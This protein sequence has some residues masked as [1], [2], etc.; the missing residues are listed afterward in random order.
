MLPAAILWDND[1][2]LVDTEI[3]YFE[4]TRGVLAEVEFDL[5]RDV[6]VDF[7][8]RQGRSVFE[9]LADRL[10]ADEVEALR[11]RRNGL[12]TETIAR[13]VRINDGV[14][15]CLEQLQPR[16]RMGIVT[17]S[18]RLHFETMHRTTDLMRYFE[19]CLTHDEYTRSKPHPEPYLTALER[20]GLDAT[21]CIVVED[22]ERGVQSAIAA[23]VRCIAIPNELT[24]D[25]D[26]SA[27][28]AVLDGVHELAGA[29]EKLG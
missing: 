9:L 22:S 25:G 8:L 11:Q 28:V 26:F 2:V 12:Y 1:G 24:R 5:G 15:E 14:R 6:F 20:H 13:G 23:G 7:A 16:M 10:P 3:L 4:V 19:F 27:A 17:G 18:S 29:L 21:T